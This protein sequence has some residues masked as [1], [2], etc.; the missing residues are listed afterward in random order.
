[1][2]KLIVSLVA[3]LCFVSQTSSGQQDARPK[4]DKFREL[5]ERQRAI[6][7]SISAGGGNFGPVRE[8]FKVGEPITVVVFMTNKG[9]EATGVVIADPYYQNRPKLMRDGEE[10]PYRKQVA[11]V[12][13]WKDKEGCGAGRIVG[14]E[15]KPNEKTEVDFLTV[16]DGPRVTGNIVWYDP[17]E[18]GKYELR[19]RR[20]FGCYQEPEAESGTIHFEVVSVE[21]A[22]PNIGMQRTRNQA[23]S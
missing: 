9:V 4:N 18:P 22:A 19:I 15:L 6:E 20:R 3:A 2:K 17:L 10:I 8:S 5:I 11:D 12:L 1:M 14:A 7:V 21:H 13:K 16:N 23:V